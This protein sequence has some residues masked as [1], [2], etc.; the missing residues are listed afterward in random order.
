MS[1]EQQ[2]QYTSVAEV[3][4]YVNFFEALLLKHMDFL[5]MIYELAADS[6]LQKIKGTCSLWFANI[7]LK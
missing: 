4:R 6:L 5:F 3:L 7:R 2:E 1:P